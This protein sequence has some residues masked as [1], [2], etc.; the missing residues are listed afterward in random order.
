MVFAGVSLGGRDDGNSLLVSRERSQSQ[1][2]MENHPLCC[3]VREKLKKQNGSFLFF[4]HPKLVKRTTGGP[5]HGKGGS[6]HL[7]V[8]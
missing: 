3:R 1:L 4:R 2:G 6:D 7:L 5:E 8:G